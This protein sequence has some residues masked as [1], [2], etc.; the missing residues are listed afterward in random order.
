MNNTKDTNTE[1]GADCRASACS[2]LIWRKISEEKPDP[3]TEVL[4]RM[5]HGM[6]SGFYEPEEDQFT[7]Y[8]FQ[9]ISWYAAEWVPIS[10]S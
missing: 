4:T 5:K 6:I 7:G 3:D 2:A 10:I 9:D 8:Y 1:A